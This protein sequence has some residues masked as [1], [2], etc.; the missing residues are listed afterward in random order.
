MLW[1]VDVDHGK[2][3]V[4]GPLQVLLYRI[5]LGARSV[6]VE[7]ESKEDIP[8]MYCGVEAPEFL[9]PSRR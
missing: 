2:S 6:F 3:I 5:S 7:R 4:D 9:G 1:D 8:A